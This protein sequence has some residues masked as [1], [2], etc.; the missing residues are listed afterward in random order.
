MK[1][2]SWLR[3]LADFLFNRRRI[4]REMD[5]EFRSH[6]ALRMADLERQGVARSDAERQARIEFGGYQQYKEECRETLGTRLL[7]ELWQDLRYGLSQLRR[8]P[9]FTIVAVLTLA[10]GIGANTAIFTVVNSVLLHPLPYPDSGRIANI[11]RWTGGDVSVPMFV[12]WEQNNPGFSH[13]AAYTDEANARINLSGSDRPT[14]VDARKASKNYFRLFGA[15]PIL[16]RTF[17]S[18]EDRTGGSEVA[19]LSYGLWQRQFGGKPSILGRKIALGGVPYT[20][21]GVLSP[22]FKPYPPTEVWVPLQADRE[23]TSQAH[24]L[25]VSGRLPA[26]TTFAQANSWMAV[27]G[28][29]YIQTHPQQLGNDDRLKVTPMQTRLTG[30][31]RPTLLILLGAVGLVLLIACANVA[32]LQLVRTS[33][34]QKEIALRAAIGAGRGRIIRQLLTE[35]LLLAFS[36]GGL[37]LVIAWAGARV[38]FLFTSA[39]LLQI[40]KVTGVPSIDL[41]V[42]GFVVLVSLVTAVAFGLLPA[43]H[44]SRPDLLVSLKESN[45]RSSAGLS[46]HRM[47]GGLAAAEVAI[48]AVSLC[49]A[50]LLVRSF[51][52]L[53]SVHPGFETRN[54][55]TLKVALAGPEYAK[56]GTV[57]RMAH[58]IV[59]R[60]D[61]IPGVELSAI[62]TMPFG[63]SGDMIFNIP[64]R[65]PLKGYK[66]TGNVL[67]YFVS[68]RYFKT[69]QIPLRSGRFFSE[70]EPAHAVIINQT[71]ARKFWPKQNPVGESIVIGAG[72]G[73]TLDQGPTEIIGVV[74]DVHDRLDAL[75]PPAMYQ[76]WSQ[77]PAAALK[78]MNQFVPAGIAVRTK[79]GV[80]PLAVGQAVQ[81]ALLA[82]EIQLPATGAET[83]QQ[84]IGDSTARASSQTAL[85]SLFGAMALL[86]ASVG[87][88]GVISYNVEQRTHEI[89]IRMALGAEKRDVLKMVIGQGLKLALIGVVIGVAGALALTRFLSS[90]LYGVKPTDPLTFIAVSLILIAVALVACYI[91]ARRASKVDPMVALRYE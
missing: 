52:A 85:L 56:P 81:Q 23:S 6:L 74:G 14:L 82:R 53:R 22:R 72:L 75:P 28:K 60:V 38:L 31:I 21:I 8:N 84:V 86:I 80:Q 79:A 30:D 20:V 88:Y 70:Q 46:H 12:F 32:N 69:L 59:D 25:M 61:R 4:E 26:G 10:L 33:G 76:L 66:F 40:E 11:T 64:G 62:G 91:P 16:G 1:F 45:D 34:R 68:P 48:A 58:Q 43:L 29:R 3:T 41:R 50:L 67:W 2:W 18:E 17:N 77:V 36:G 78:L 7:Q 39:G 55:L 57:D 49:G 19:V 90:L 63:P 47:R 42:A 87:I 37:G 13:L 5:E 15:N 71:M 89:G 35:S 44:L 9:G 24:I 54:L 65:P 73:P 27:L 51:L 83:M